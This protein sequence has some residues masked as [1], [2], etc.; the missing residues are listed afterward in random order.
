MQ[1]REFIEDDGYEDQ[2]WWKAGGYGEYK[3]PEDWQDQREF[4][5]RPVVGVSWLEAAA[6]CAWSGYRLPT[7]AEWERAARGPRTTARRFPWGE[8][9]A[10]SNRLNYESEVWH[11]SPVGIFPLGGTPEEIQDL[12]G[13]VW[14][15]CADWFD[16]DYYARSPAKSPLGPPK[17]AYR[18][19]RGGGWG[20]DAWLCRAAFRSRGVPA[21]RFGLLGFRVAAVPLGGAGKKHK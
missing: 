19:S 3:E 15:W 20:Y 9:A 13:N 6:F 21:S 12:A 5:N 14:E 16:E 11:A 18:V 1:Y 2:R 10:D 4:L 17:A 7:E 8:E